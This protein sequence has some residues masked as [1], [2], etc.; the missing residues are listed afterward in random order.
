M[1][2][3]R[4]RNC[5]T[6]YSSAA[7]DNAFGLIY[8]HILQ[9]CHGWNI[10]SITISGQPEDVQAA[11]KNSTWVRKCQRQLRRQGRRIAICNA[12]ATSIKALHNI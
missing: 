3:A 1:D 7:K 2:D 5:V 8:N 9:T 10:A 6:A 12:T 11:L 4:T